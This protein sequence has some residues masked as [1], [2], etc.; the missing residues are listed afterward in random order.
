VLYR[1]WNN[2][3][4]NNSKKYLVVYNN[5]AEPSPF[6][7]NSRSDTSPTFLGTRNFTAV[8]TRARHRSPSWATWIQSTPPYPMSLRYILISV[9]HLRYVF[10]MVSSLSTETVCAFLFLPMSAR[11]VNQV[12]LY[13]V[14]PKLLLLIKY[15]ASNLFFF[16]HIKSET[17]TVFT[18]PFNSFTLIFFYRRFLCCDVRLAQCIKCTLIMQNKMQVAQRGNAF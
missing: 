12:F 1:D 10:L 8:F 16:S 2:Y 5:S 18:N 6:E 7:V 15:R 17:L 4:S 14:F 3:F 13:R 9:S 11:T